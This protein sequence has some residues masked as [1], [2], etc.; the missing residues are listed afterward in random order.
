M[1]KGIIF[2][3][4]V[5]LVIGGFYFF[6][7][8][9]DQNSEGLMSGE[10]SEQMTASLASLLSGNKNLECSFEHTDESGSQSGVG[11]ISGN[12]FRGDFKLTQADLDSFDMHALRDS[13]WTYTWGGPLGETKGIKMKNIAPDSAVENKK[14]NSFDFDQEYSIE[15]KPWS[16]DN[17]K[18]SVPSGIDFQDL[19]AMTQQVTNSMTNSMPDLKGLQC[20]ACDQAPEGAA[21]EQCKKALGC[22]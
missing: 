5:V 9:R 20:A 1:N 12:S 8:N 3:V 2:L 6:G 11:Y 15:C 4:L 14:D 16:P 19:S 18:F 7:P 22:N 21:R 10:N 17:S 13:E